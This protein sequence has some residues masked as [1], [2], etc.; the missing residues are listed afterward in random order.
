MRILPNGR[1]L[2]RRSYH[3]HRNLGDRYAPTSVFGL[4]DLVNVRLLLLK[5]IML[6]SGQRSSHTRL[7]HTNETLLV[8]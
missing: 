5:T 7:G 4:I 1:Q 3:Q 2:V 6:L 8:A